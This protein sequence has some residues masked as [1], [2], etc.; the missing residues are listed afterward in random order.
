LC[1]PLLRLRLQLHL[2]YRPLQLLPPPLLMLLL[3]LSLCCRA[4]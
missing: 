2:P 3:L 1:L 4:A